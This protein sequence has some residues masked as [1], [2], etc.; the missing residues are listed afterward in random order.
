MRNRVRLSRSRSCPALI[1]QTER[2]GQLRG[3]NV[4]LEAGGWRPHSSRPG[5]RA[6]E[7]FG[8]ELHAIGAHR[9][10]PP[11]RLR[12]RIDKEADPDA[13][14]VQPSMISTIISRGVLADHPA[15]LVISPGLT[16]TSVHWCGRT[17]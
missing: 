13:A 17:S 16:G 2:V 5:E 8:V 6:R 10:R 12:H 9:R 3:G 11:N 15:W 7:R 14:I 4:G 1:A